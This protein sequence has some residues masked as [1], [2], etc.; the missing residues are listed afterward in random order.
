MQFVWIL[1]SKLQVIQKL[2]Y[3]IGS[4]VTEILTGFKGMISFRS[5]KKKD[6]FCNSINQNCHKIS[7]IFFLA[8]VFGRDRYIGHIESQAAIVF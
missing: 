2:N 8:K 4:K 7:I 1:D 5:S 3:C 6:D